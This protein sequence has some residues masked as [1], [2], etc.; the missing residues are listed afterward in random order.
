MKSRSIGGVDTTAAA[1]VVAAVVAAVLAGGTAAGA[2]AGAFGGCAAPSS[3]RAVL[4]VDTAVV[5]AIA[6]RGSGSSSSRESVGFGAPAEPCTAG[7][8]ATSI[9]GGARGT[10]NS[11]TGSSV[12]G[13][14]AA[15]GAAED[16]PVAPDADEPPRVAGR[17][18]ALAGGGEAAGAGR[19]GGTV[20]IAD[21]EAGFAGDA[22]RVG[23]AAVAGGRLA[24][25]GVVG[26]AE[27]GL[28]AGAVRPVGASGVEGR[29]DAIDGSR[30][31]GRAGIAAPPVFAGVVVV[32]VIVAVAGVCDE[33]DG[34]VAAD[35]GA[36]D[37]D[38]A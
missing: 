23:V 36:A 34:R 6:G 28:T 4:A 12:R 10:S 15:T 32:C 16:T 27:A 37:A 8:M 38:A 11:S 14:S 30:V 33:V 31:S 2:P 18:G 1:A 21:F 29:M 35:P 22:L 3:F 17:G 13:S 26:A 20:G 24:V 25:A 9:V 19:A 7:G 5:P